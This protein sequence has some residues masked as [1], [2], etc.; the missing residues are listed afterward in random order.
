MLLRDGKG[1]LWNVI[2]QTITHLFLKMKMMAYVCLIQYNGSFFNM[3]TY[4]YP[5]CCVHIYRQ[6][7][8]VAKNNM[9]INVYKL[10]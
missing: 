2:D 10:I 7:K 9:D 3:L 5:V 6:T 4:T 8:E 1:I